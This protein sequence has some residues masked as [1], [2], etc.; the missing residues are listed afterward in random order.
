M[1]KSGDTVEF[2]ILTH[3][4]N[5]SQQAFSKTKLPITINSYTPPGKVLPLEKCDFTLTMYGAGYTGFDP[6]N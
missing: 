2:L 6:A 4:I 5:L 3:V 1:V